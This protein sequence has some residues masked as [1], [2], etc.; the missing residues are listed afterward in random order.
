MKKIA[1]LAVLA[2]LTTDGSV[3]AS[4][5]EK[6]T[7][8]DTV[9]MESYDLMELDRSAQI[10]AREHPRQFLE[11]QGF[12][13]REVLKAIHIEGGDGGVECRY[14]HVVYPEHQKSRWI[15]YCP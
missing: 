3:L 14:Y 6:L 5:H 4:E 11:K 15:W 10:E 7:N 12:E 1:V 9:V 8:P 2:G 13:V